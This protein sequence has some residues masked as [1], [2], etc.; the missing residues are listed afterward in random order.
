MIKFILVLVKK[1]PGPFLSKVVHFD[2]FNHT[3]ELLLREAANANKTLLRKS[4]L[5]ELAKRCPH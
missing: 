3:V 1:L 4:V 2:G 5:K